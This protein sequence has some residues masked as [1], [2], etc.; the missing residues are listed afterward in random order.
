MLTKFWESLGSGLSEKWLSLLGPA[1]VFWGGGLFLAVGWNGIGALSGR[2]LG[3]TISQQVLV[4]VSILILLLGSA[5]F[6][7]QMSYP[8]L[9]FLEGYWGT[10]LRW[11]QPSLIK[12]Q[13]SRID[14]WELQW[15]SLA[16]RRSKGNLSTAE[17]SRFLELERKLHYVPSDPDDYMPTTLGNILR[18]AETQPKLKYGLDPIICWPRLWAFLSGP[19]RE[20]LGQSR[21]SMNQGVELW[22]WGILFLLWSIWSWWAIPV[23]L[24]WA[25]TAYRMTINAATSYADLVETAFD[26]QRWDLYKALHFKLPTS[27]SN[28]VTSG[29]EVTE[30]LW[31]G[32]AGRNI[33]FVHPKS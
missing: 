2:L 28:E 10:P 5:S 29:E 12:S 30:Y 6:L 31:R 20:E 32:T 17:S 27:T 11:L 33:R 9:R 25:W 21:T 1:F 23:S 26:T 4:L 8:I 3:L 16:Q 15:Q 18:M 14:R 7:Q 24:V 19:L 22:A 13:K